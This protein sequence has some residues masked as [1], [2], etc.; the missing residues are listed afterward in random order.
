MDPVVNLVRYIVMRILICMSTCWK[1]LHKSIQQSFIPNAKRV[2]KVK[3]FKFNK[4]LAK[5]E[6]KETKGKTS[7]HLICLNCESQTAVYLSVCQ[8]SQFNMTF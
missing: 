6:Y 4:T 3:V 8:I 5:F 1:K 2:K 7:I